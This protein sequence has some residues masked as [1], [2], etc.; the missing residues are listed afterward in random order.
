MT[1]SEFDNMVQFL[2]RGYAN[3]EVYLSQLSL[4]LL[5]QS[6]HPHTKHH[7]FFVDNSLSDNE[8][9]PSEI[10]N[11]TTKKRDYNPILDVREIPKEWP[12]NIMSMSVA[13][14]ILTT[15]VYVTRGAYILAIQK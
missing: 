4:N 13:E 15:P 8:F 9:K 10:W 12:K 6:K 7:T 11:S 14:A 1:V 3:P 5:E 2:T